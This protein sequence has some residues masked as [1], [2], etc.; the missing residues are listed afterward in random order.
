VR[1]Y[2][3]GRESAGLLLRLQTLLFGLL[4][5]SAPAAPR[6]LP[7]LFGVLALTA[8]VHVLS[9]DRGRLLALLRAPVVIALG[10]FIAYLFVSAAWAHDPG[11]GLTKAAGM[12]G[13]V[14]GAVFVAASFSL[15]DAEETCRLARAAVTGLLLG[16]VYL[17]IELLLNE[18]IRRFIANNIIQLFDV[19]PKKMEVVNGEII[20]MKTSVLNRNVISFVLLLIPGLLFTAALASRSMRHAALGALVLAAAVCVTMSESGTSL[21]A[22][23][24][25]MVALAFCALSL[26]AARM[27]M[28]VVWTVVMLFA[29][30][31]SALP[32][33][34]GWN[35]LASVSPESVAA[36]FYIWKHMADAVEKN[37]VIGIGV[38]GARALDV[39]LPADL[40]SLRE[41]A[42][43]ADGRRV[44][45]PHNVFLQIWLEL[46][47]IGA[48]LA[49]VVGLAALWQIGR[50]PPVVQAGALGLFAVCAGV[51]A[52]GFDLWQTWLLGAYIFTWPALLLAKGLPGFALGAAEDRPA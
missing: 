22:F 4:F 28:M 35:R 34:Q 41:P 3:V 39:R 21:V 43:V 17:L 36:R 30:P 45:H 27:A 6:A 18:P 49:L 37:F 11:T 23:V 44:P 29:V 50:L 40:R 24:L 25:G 38:R 42:P 5:F 14:A 31:L 33:E 15:R 8:A 2:F 26:K 10:V 47:A 46:G 1:A 9:T 12:L 51:G 32:Y 16:A 19:V 20:D 7:A 13:L 52:S 48:F